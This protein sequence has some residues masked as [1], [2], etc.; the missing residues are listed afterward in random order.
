MKCYLEYKESG[1]AWIGEIPR[2]WEVK[3]LKYIAD[4]NMGQSPPSDNLDSE[5]S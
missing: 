5:L 3:R 1:V 2:Y 4:L